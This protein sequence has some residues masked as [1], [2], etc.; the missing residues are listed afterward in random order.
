M[1]RLQV[2]NSRIPCCGL[3]VRLRPQTK[4]GATFLIRCV[5]KPHGQ[6][7][8][9]VRDGER[10]RCVW[11]EEHNDQEP[12]PVGSDRAYAGHD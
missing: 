11:W 7:V 1:P 6:R 9:V 5:H 4:P 12:D 3:L 8:T 10:L 2:L